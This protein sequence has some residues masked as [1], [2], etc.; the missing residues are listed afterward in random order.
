MTPLALPVD[1]PTVVSRALAEDLG[2]ADLTAELRLM[3][4]DSARYGV[5]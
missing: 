4:A 3:T 2:A 1:I 5:A